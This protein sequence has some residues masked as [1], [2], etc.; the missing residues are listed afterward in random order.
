MNAKLIN[1]M[2]GI[3]LCYSVA[4]TPALAADT[5]N[6]NVALLD[7][8]SVMSNGMMGMMAPGQGMMGE[9]WNWNMMGSGQGMMGR[10]WGMMGN[11]QGMMGNGMMGRGGGMMGMMSIRIDRSSVKAGSIHFAVTNWSR[12]MVHE[13]LVVAVDNPNAPV[14]YDYGANKIPEEQIKS[15]GE[16]DKLEANASGSLDVSLP[17]GNYL[18]ICNVEGH[19]AAGMVAPFTVVP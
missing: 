19:F 15:L 5:T 13:M 17:P 16:V 9:D 11:G 10:G 6:V 2:A 18:L 4:A 7:M 14:P 8:S 1:S 3:L 12:G